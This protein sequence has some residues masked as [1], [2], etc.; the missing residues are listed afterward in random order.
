MILLVASLVA[1]AFALIPAVL[2]VSNLGRFSTPA[3]PAADAPAVS[4]L[5][6]ARD[7][8]ATIGACLEAVLASSGLDLEAIV[9]DDC[10]ADDTAAIVRA[11]AARDPRV[12]LEPAPPLPEGWCGKQ[13]AC[14]TLARLATHDVLVFLD[15]DVRL[16]PDALA[17]GTAFLARSGAALVSGFPRQETGSALERLLLPL[18]HFVLLGFLPLGRMRRSTAPAYGAGCGQWFITRRDDYQRAG[19]HAAIRASLHDGIMLP[20]AYRAAGMPTDLFDATPLASCR[21]Y[22]GAAQTWRGLAKNAAEGMAAPA[23]IVP[24]TLILLA[25][26]VLPLALV[27]ALLS[28][29]AESMSRG[30][31]EAALLAAGAA[32]LAGFGVRFAAAARFR[33]SWLGAALHPV[34]VTLLLAVQWYALGKSLLGQPAVWRGRPYPSRA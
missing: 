6:P 30:A 1:L 34:G 14:H 33:Q 18:I 5:I 21:M 26:Q 31:N 25:G 9:L 24:W 11:I 32:T 10:S 13:H 28:A 22:H 19:A 23:A 15:A 2:F 27:V 12:R 8:A 3:A 16:T 7:E 4:V 17:R 20:R 29:P